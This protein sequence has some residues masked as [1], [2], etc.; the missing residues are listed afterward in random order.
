MV[1]CELARVRPWCV[2]RALERRCTRHARSFGAS[3]HACINGVFGHYHQLL[4]QDQMGCESGPSRCIVR[5]EAA[6][7]TVVACQVGLQPVDA[8]LADPDCQKVVGIAR[9]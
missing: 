4:L 3:A 5:A 6:V 2:R 8:Y 7:T 9:S 1:S